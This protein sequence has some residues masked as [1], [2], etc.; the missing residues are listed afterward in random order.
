MHLVQLLLP[1]YDNEKRAFARDEYD[2]V[3]REL[4]E[5]FGGVT[6]HVRAPAEGRWKKDDESEVARDEVVIYE[7]MTHA[8]ERDWWARYRDELAR[9]FRQEELLIRASEVERL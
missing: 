8:L 3:R 5:R 2:R 9:R 4:T 1:L 6:A 7:V